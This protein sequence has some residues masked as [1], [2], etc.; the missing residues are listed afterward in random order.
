M[1]ELG[2]RASGQGRIF[3][4][5]GDQYIQEHHHHYGAGAGGP[6]FGRE[7]GPSAGGSGPAAPDSVRIPLVGRPPGI[8]RDRRE[9]R[10]LLSAAVAG[11]GGEVHVVH[12]MGGCGKTALAYWL[13]TDAVREHGRVGFWVNASE[14]MSLRAGMLAVAGDRGASSGELAAAAAGQRAAADVAW[15]Y[16]GRSA[17][18]WL[19]VLDNADD[20]AVLEEGAWLR[21]GG[22][23]TVLVTTRHATSPLWHTPGT[24]LHALGV[25]P[26]DD[27]AQVLCDLAPGAGDL[28]SA[29]KVAARL[30][31]LPLALTLAG[32]H[33][34]RPLLESWSM[35]E[36]ERKLDEE[37]TVIVDRGAM[38]YG[39]GQSRHLV[40]RTWQLSL[41]ALAGQGLSEATT[42]LRL[43]SF[44]AAGPVPL[45]L[46]APLARGEIAA[47]GLQ[48]AL[49]PER[50]EAALRGLL[51]HSLAE[52][53]EA[54]G[55]RC[56]QAHGVLLDSVAAGIS[57]AQRECLAEVAGGLL[58]TAL[59]ERGDVSPESRRRLALLAPHGSRLLETAPGE[60]SAA[61]GVRLVRQVYETA[62]YGAAMALSRAVADRTRA[63]LGEDHPVALD[64]RD[65]VGRA[66]FRVGRY[67]ESETVHRQVL[68]RREALLGPDDPDTLRSCAGLHR[69]LDLLD[70]D[71]EA[72]HWLRRAIEGMRRVLGEDS[73]ETLY[74][75]TSLPEVL[76]QLGRERECDAELALLIPACERA[77]PADHL[78]L[79]MARHMQAY[80]LWQ[81]GRFAEA[82]PV[83]RRVLDDRMRIVGPDN[84]FTFAARGLLAEIVHGLGRHAE[85]IA[86]VSRVVEDSDRV[87][88][89]EHPIVNHYS[90][91]LARYRTEPGAP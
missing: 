44:L 20:P 2:A 41:D 9:L 68:A 24:R 53:V 6:L 26:L 87:L 29:R 32:S 70:R 50:L 54:E 51:D 31:G 13:F 91:T 63:L 81:F 35:D 73:P 64:A 5:S 65:V 61:L 62:D 19:L 33:L 1:S 45:S 3:Q 16:L 89:P 77:L 56:V 88:G 60:R 14:R 57:D 84:R 49:P 12:G 4:T 86:L 71:E 30:D 46:L 67:E 76:S 40:S 58:E 80:A 28:R 27:A 82:E 42:V 38:G 43:L 37:S 21:A 59:P 75:W 17:E 52:L 23:G 69:P 10:A 78:T 48:L 34:A 25:L 72:E 39:G 11:P 66:L 15:H 18:P 7:G 55:V 79:V 22:Q 83:A 90:A 85:A 8:L 47:T 36:Y 74:T